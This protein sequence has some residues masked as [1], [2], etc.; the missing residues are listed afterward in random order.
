M[1]NFNI[2]GAH[3]KVR[4]LGGFTKNKYRGDWTVC[5]FKG[6]LE[7]RGGG[8]FDGRGVDTPMDTMWSIPLM[9]LLWK[10][11]YQAISDQYRRETVKQII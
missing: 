6:G 5:Q 10:T 11:H 3:W 1:K 2:L 9:D 8:V 7:E 4:L